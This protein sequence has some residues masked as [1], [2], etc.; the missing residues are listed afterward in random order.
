MKE[1]PRVIATLD[2]EQF[3]AAKRHIAEAERLLSSIA[4]RHADQSMATAANQA[5]QMDLR[6][7]ERASEVFIR[8][9]GVVHSLDVSDAFG[10]KYG[11]PDSR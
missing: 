2:L 6:G 4:D 7:A 11:F 10:E 1:V 3:H 9:C 5:A 8:Y